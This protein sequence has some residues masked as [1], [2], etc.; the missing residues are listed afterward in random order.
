MRLAI[1]SVPTRCVCIST[2]NWYGNSSSTSRTAQVTRGRRAISARPPDRGP[3]VGPLRMLVP[4]SGGS[5]RKLAAAALCSFAVN[6]FAADIDALWEYGDPAASET[7]FRTAL[8]ASQGDARL[9]L[10]TQIARTYSLRRRFDESHRM[11]DEVEPA[12]ASA[13]PAPHVRYLLER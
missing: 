6:T 3:S 1:R 11:L 9:E 7:R 12:L 5:L 8:A 2:G 10:L 13:G 4:T